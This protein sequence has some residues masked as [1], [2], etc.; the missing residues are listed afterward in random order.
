VLTSS[1]F[2][3]YS[4]LP[5]KCFADPRVSVAKQNGGIT[6]APTFSTSAAPSSEFLG[7][8][9]PFPDIIDTA[10]TDVSMP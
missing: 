1:L 9:D 4:L 10:L 2:E 6:S 5:D 7:L 3:E 8:H